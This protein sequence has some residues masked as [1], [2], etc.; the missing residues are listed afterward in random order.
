MFPGLVK[1]QRSCSLLNHL[2]VLFAV[3]FGVAFDATKR[4]AP[5]A[6]GTCTYSTKLQ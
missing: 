2:N 3:I 6:I 4:A 5:N 1:A